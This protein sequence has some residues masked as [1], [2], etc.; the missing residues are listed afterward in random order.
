MNKEKSRGLNEINAALG[1]LMLWRTGRRSRA[2]P[3]TRTTKTAFQRLVLRGVFSITR[4][5]SAMTKHDLSLMINLPLRTIQIWFQNERNK[6][7]RPGRASE[8]DANSSQSAD[9][10]PLTIFDIILFVLNEK[11]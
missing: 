9:I 10:G 4:H 2:E 8:A 11:L 3:G 5:P 6:R 1:L 7:Q